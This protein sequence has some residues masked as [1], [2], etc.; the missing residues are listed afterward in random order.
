MMKNW[1]SILF[2]F[3]G[4]NNYAQT[5]NGTVFNEKNEPLTGA[6]VQI[7]NTFIGT[8]TNSN[9]KFSLDATQADDVILVISFFIL[10]AGISTTL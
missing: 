7:E 2:L 5:I 10:E 4:S 9:G 3:I 6:S 1:L 8:F